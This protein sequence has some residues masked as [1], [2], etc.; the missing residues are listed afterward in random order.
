MK[1]KI[2]CL[3]LSL[4]V[5]FSA[6]A[7]QVVKVQPMT[8]AVLSTAVT[9]STG[10]VPLPATAMVGRETICIFNNDSSVQLF[11]GHSSV[12][13]INGLPI[14]PK[15]AITIDADDSVVIYGI[16]ASSINV[17]VLECK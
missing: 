12:S 9:V 6:Y 17:R 10:A 15:A 2:L 7:I 5:A 4:S 16:A 14:Q 3:I 13:V 1:K 11:V 8:Y